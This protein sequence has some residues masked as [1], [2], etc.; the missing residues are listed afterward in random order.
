MQRFLIDILSRSRDSKGLP[1]EEAKRT[2]GGKAYLQYGKYASLTCL[3]YRSIPVLEISGT[4]QPALA[5]P[6]PVQPI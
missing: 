5:K 4:Q 3:P 6:T 2:C 1:S